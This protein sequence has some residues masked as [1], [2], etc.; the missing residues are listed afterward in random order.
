MRSRG[1][2]EEEQRWSYEE[3]RRKRGGAE[4]EQ[5]KSRGE[6]MRNRGGREEELRRSRGGAALTCL[7]ESSSSVLDVQSLQGE[8]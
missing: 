4:E 8:L 7:C 1:G 6:A 3:Q 5:K 2:A